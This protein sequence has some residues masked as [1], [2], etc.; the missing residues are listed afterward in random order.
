MFLRKYIT[1]THIQQELGT[2]TLQVSSS[3]QSDLNVSADAVE[4]IILQLRIGN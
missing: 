3:L 1:E 2:Y 4:D